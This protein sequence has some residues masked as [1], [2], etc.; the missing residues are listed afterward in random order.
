MQTPELF[1]KRAIELA[2]RAR[3]NTSPNPLVG[4]VIVRDNKIIAEGWHQQSGLAHAEVAAIRD[5][6]KKQQPTQG[7]TIYVSLEPCSHYGK[8]P[9]CTQAILDAGFGEVVY[10]TS[11]TN[12]QASGGAEILKAAGVIVTGGVCEEIAR[13]TNRFFFH[14]QQHK[15]PFVLA[16]FASSLDGRTATRTGNSKW[17]TGLKA[18]QRG[19]EVRQA[20]DAIVIG[21]QTAIN[22]Q[23]QL[24]V[25]NPDAHKHTHAAH[26][27]RIVLDS[28]GSVP[29]DNAIFDAS[30]PAKTMV[31]TTSAM[32]A[33][34]AEK[35]HDRGIEVLPL[36]CLEN[37]ALPDLKILL[38][39]LGKRHIQSLLV[40]GGH[41]VHGSFFDH[42]LVDE[43]WAFMAPIIIGGS[44][45][46]PSVGGLG[47]DELIGA[48]T[49]SGVDI[50][51][52]EPDF[53]I[54]GQVNYL[55]TERANDGTL[56]H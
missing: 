46:M 52:L 26:P 13:H 29:I 36:P 22:D 44:S 28:R 12:S 39:T 7:A 24:T 17:I 18:R 49:L 33:T 41:T 51:W 56:Q 5:A 32:P 47:A 9:P 15:T 55:H 42:Q 2:N 48:A 35:L 34:H 10:A 50:E 43:V 16:K 38:N 1:M 4:A 30:L 14:Y 54:K 3:G 8:T 23:P 20:V 19:H 45:A 37:T 27:V 25:R 53:L 31:V 11:D 6:A 21:A 40:E